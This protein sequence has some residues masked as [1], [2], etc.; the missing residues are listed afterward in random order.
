MSELVQGWSVFE[1]SRVK[2]AAEI[3]H[4]FMEAEDI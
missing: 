2:E 4:K 3:L 1:S